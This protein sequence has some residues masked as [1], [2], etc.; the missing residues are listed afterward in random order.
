[1]IDDQYV[2]RKVEKDFAD[3]YPAN[4]DMHAQI[5]GRRSRGKLFFWVFLVA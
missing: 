5:S 4:E 2:Q 1:M 3:F